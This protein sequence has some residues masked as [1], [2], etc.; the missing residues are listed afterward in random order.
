MALLW[1]TCPGSSY[2]TQSVTDVD[3]AN[4]AVVLLSD[5]LNIYAIVHELTPQ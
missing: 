5:L 3:D 4:A 2:P 1:G